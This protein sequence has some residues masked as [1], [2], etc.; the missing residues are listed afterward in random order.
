MRF[1]TEV[2]ERIDAHSFPA[3]TQELIDAYGTIEI[4]LPNGSET[5]GDTM[6]PFES[7][8]F[9]T[10]EDARLTAYSALGEAAIGRKGYSDRDPTALGEDGHEQMSL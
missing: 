4:D 10:A 2:T 5:F 9:E 8:T 6:G 3:T 7:Q 1:M